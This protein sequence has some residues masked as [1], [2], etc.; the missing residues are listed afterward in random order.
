MHACLAWLPAALS[1]FLILFL[2]FLQI[3]L[4][5]QFFVDAQFHGG[6]FRQELFPVVRQSVPQREL[7]RAGI[8]DDILASLD[9]VLHGRLEALFGARDALFGNG[10]PNVILRWM[11]LFIIVIF[12][13]M[14]QQR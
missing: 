2:V 14:V 9:A 5:A 4:F 12:I 1:S 11:L 10:E 8:R 6:W 3:L 13:T 7:A